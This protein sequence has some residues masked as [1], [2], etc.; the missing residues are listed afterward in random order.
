MSLSPTINQANLCNE[1]DTEEAHLW[2][3]DVANLISEYFGL[4]H[5]SQQ[6]VI[7][8]EEVHNVVNMDGI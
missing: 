3:W 8:L 5:H 2:D 7:I 6:E 4:I 1:C